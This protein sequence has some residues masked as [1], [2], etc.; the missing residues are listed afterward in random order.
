L[1]NVT[2]VITEASDDHSP[3]DTILPGYP[4][5]LRNPASCCFGT[6][7][8]IKPPSDRLGA[9]SASPAVDD[10]YNCV[11]WNDVNVTA[12]Q[13]DKTAPGCRCA[14]LVDLIIQNS[15]GSAR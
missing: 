8:G 14:H 9:F 3:G 12:P 11:L 2:I 5:V 10:L 13:C 1:N 7:D 4:T 15:E 6:P